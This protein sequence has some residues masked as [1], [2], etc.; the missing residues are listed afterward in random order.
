MKKFL[1]L[2]ISETSGHHTTA[3][4]IE[5][6]LQLFSK[7]SVSIQTVNALYYLYPYFEKVIMKAYMGVVKK[8]PD[9]WEYLYDNHKVKDKLSGWRER[10]HRRNIPKIFELIMAK[11]PDVIICTQAYPCGI[12][13]AFKKMYGFDF[14]LYAVV[15]DY[16][17][18]S[19]WVFDS[20]D[21]YIVPTEEVKEQLMSKGVLEER[22]KCFGIPLM[23]RFYKKHDL[24][25]TKLRYGINN[26]DKVVTIMGG[27][28]GLLPMKKIIKEL[29]SLSFRLHIIAIA[30]KNEKLYDSLLALKKKIQHKISVLGYIT[31]VP[32]IMEISDILISKP[33][34]V[35]ITEALV[36]ELPMVIVRPLPGQ[37]AK[38]T[39]FL[40]K[41]NIAIKIDSIE[42]LS[43]MLTNLFA[44][45]NKIEQMKDAM[46]L[47]RNPRSLQLLTSLILGN[48][49]AA[50]LEV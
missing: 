29:D 36:K 40:I 33:G 24:F 2:Y 35:T 49:D 44:H 5:T 4:A 22:I 48:K 11:R 34:G 26:G 19:Y 18:H 1:I 12:L 28:Q 3:T 16:V 32:Q 14:E 41:N 43:G 38:N 17:A 39:E 15:T 45:E 47:L 9:I 46:R 10:T 27:G 23:P 25:E 31:A 42:E 30:G 7:D 50:L 13:N 21:H 20:V 8:A 37:E 6:G